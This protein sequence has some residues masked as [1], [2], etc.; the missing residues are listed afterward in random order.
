MQVIELKLT[1]ILILNWESLWL[2]NFNPKKCK[3]MHLIYN[4]NNP[5]NQYFIN[6]VL[7]EKVKT[8]RDVGL[9]VSENLG[10]DENIRSCI[11]YK[12]RCIGWISRNLINRDYKI[13][14]RVY[15][16]IIRP[17]LE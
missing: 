7:L 14:S 3:I 11:K 17:R 9:F 1:K 4:L 13:L 8:E 5:L 2:L 15:N 6:L 12:N 16:T 10:W